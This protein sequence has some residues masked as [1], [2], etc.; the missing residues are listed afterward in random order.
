MLR[1]KIMALLFKRSMFTQDSRNKSEND[2]SWER[3]LSVCCKFLKRIYHTGHSANSLRSKP[4]VANNCVGRSMIEML[5]V[6][7]IIGVLSVG[8]IAGYSYLTQGLLEHIDNL[9]NLKSD[10]GNNKYDLAETIKGLNL[11]PEGWSFKNS[12]V[13]SDTVG[14]TIT[15]FIR[16]SH[17]VYDIVLGNASS[18][19]GHL[20]S[21][22]FSTKLCR[23]FIS[24]FAQPLHSSLKF[25]WIFRTKNGSIHYYGDS[26]CTDSNMCLVNMTLSDIQNVCISCAVGEEYCLFVLEF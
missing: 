11:L 20:V 22:N 17:L 4:S 18:V 3:G 14:S 7:A 2:G 21:D 19:D 23:E 6:L 10:N 25:A 5:G 16:D 15:I 9:R 12:T 13:I 1:G 24:N 26:Q 8:G